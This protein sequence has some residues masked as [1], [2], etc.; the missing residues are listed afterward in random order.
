MGHFHVMAAA[1]EKQEAFCT[2]RTVIKKRTGR[3]D[4]II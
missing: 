1:G 2:A 4:F 3:R